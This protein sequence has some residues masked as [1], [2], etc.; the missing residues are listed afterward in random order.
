MKVLFLTTPTSDCTNHVNAFQSFAPA[1]QL[2]MTYRGIRIDER[3]AREV[4]E[5]GPDVIFY[6]SA[7]QG[8]FALKYR[9][10]ANLKA[11]SP[12]IN[13]CSD[14]QDKPWH[15]IL[16]VYEKHNCFNLQVSL[17]GGKYKAI[18][19]ST[20]TP[21]DP[22]HYNG[23]EI[24][25]DIKCGFSGS[26]G[27]A[28][29]RSELVH[30]LEWFGGLTVRNRSLNGGYED[31][32]KFMR[33][34][35]ILLNTSWTGTGDDHHIKGRVMEAGWAGC[36]LLEA[37]ASPISDWFPE[38]CYFSWGDAK[39]AAYIIANASDKE[40]SKRATRLSEEVRKHFSP[41]A[42]YGE[43]LRLA[44]VDLP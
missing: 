19:Y 4:R 39:E 2:V 12:I 42:I 37:K 29:L 18:G 41:K 33:R 16:D 1:E 27:T 13:L 21:V 20:L 7:N 26:V 14:A 5:I 31:H 30:A 32:V 28:G 38:D 44:N 22:T 3:I 10:L 8:P 6:I 9:T 35:K 25:R 17:D 34:C 15:G 40:I 23:T 43:I 24:K 36:A 11:I